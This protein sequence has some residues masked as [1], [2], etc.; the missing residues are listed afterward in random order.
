MKI[1]IPDFI[2]I[3]G[4]RPL[5][6]DAQVRVSGA[7]N[8]VLGA[9][10]AALL[11]DQPVIFN[12]VPFITDVVDM[13]EIFRAIGASVDYAPEKNRIEIRAEKITTNQLPDQALNFRASYYIW[14]AL[15]ARFKKT[16]EWG[17]L[18]IKIPGGCAFGGARAINFHIDLLDN[19]FGAKL[20]ETAEALE[21]VLPDNFDGALR[22]IYSTPKTSHGATF[23][24]MLAA[25]LSPDIKMI[26]NASLEHE[27]PHLL[28]IL[29]QMGANIRG[30]NTTAIT[31]LGFGGR[32]LGGGEFDIMPDRMEAGFYTLLALALRSKIKIIGADL[33]SSRPWFN[34]IVEIAGADRCVARGEIMYFDFTDL[35]PFLGRT[36]ITSPIPGK[37]TDMQQCWTPVLAQA[38]D[39]S[40]IFDPIYPGR[41]GHLPELKKFGIETDFSEV[42][43]EN[44]L[45]PKAAKI[46][47]R[48]SRIHAA[49][50]TGMDLRG[51]AALIIAAAV[52]EGQ[53]RI[54]LPKF[55]LRGY[56]NLIGNLKKLGVEIC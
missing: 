55:A 15:L 52:A 11:T 32:L 54:D 5:A 56:P 51:T 19:I 40:L 25:A 4:G 6:D 38:T 53:S 42:E 49:N 17:S 8:E 50:A 20:T 26:Y 41:V 1:D 16:G 31:N 33:A 13:V 10:C 28:G 2:E 7:K 12:N 29:N 37:E 24:W 18:R 22:P 23:H 48:P 34:S 43:I 30:T 39:E 35:P 47:V 36:M 27:V 44:P 21:F 45:T 46:I 9:M 14:G 3:R